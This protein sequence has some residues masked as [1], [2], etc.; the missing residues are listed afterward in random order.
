VGC[1][2]GSEVV[3][4][5]NLLKRLVEL[6]E[7]RNTLYSE[8]RERHYSG[9]CDYPAA[10]VDD[11]PDDECESLR[12]RLF[13]ARIMFKSIDDAVTMELNGTNGRDEWKDLKS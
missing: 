2:A 11:C 6:N 1:V 13:M 8:Y 10:P 12:D 7:E 3:I 9:T 5:Q 4:E